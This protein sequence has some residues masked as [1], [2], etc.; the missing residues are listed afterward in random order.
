[1][2]QK[3]IDTKE[4]IMEQRHFVYVIAFKCIFTRLPITKYKLL[5]YIYPHAEIYLKFIHLF[6]I[7]FRGFAICQLLRSFLLLYQ[8]NLYVLN[9]L[10]FFI[11]NFFLEERSVPR[12]S[13][14]TESRIDARSMQIAAVNFI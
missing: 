9:F 14:S 3:S 10:C 13:R 2:S 11:K 7:Y 6:M 8:Q 4:Q 5:K 12:Q 1:M